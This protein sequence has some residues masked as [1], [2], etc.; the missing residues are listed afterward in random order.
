MRRSMKSLKK[1]FCS[2]F[3]FASMAGMM[4]A[5]E[6]VQEQV[7]AKQINEESSA[8]EAKPEEKT[9]DIK[10]QEM[11]ELLGQLEQLYP[12]KV[13]S[14]LAKML[15]SSKATRKPDYVGSFQHL[16]ARTHAAFLTGKVME[17]PRFQG[18][19]ANKKAPFHYREQLIQLSLT[20]DNLNERLYEFF[21]KEQT[22]RFARVLREKLRELNISVQTILQ[23]T[24]VIDQIQERE[25]RHLFG[26]FMLWC[27]KVEP[28]ISENN[29]NKELLL[30]V[31]KLLCEEIAPLYSRAYRY[32]PPTLGH[33][34]SRAQKTIVN[35][36]S[37]EI[38]IMCMGIALLSV[39]GTK[40]YEAGSSWLNSSSS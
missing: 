11:A 34:C 7:G 24:V 6:P 35:F 2:A 36:L 33:H 40:L 29:E 26:D 18:S 15:L 12:G 38:V 3:A 4:L 28:K 14:E 17:V 8:R 22:S 5:G 27:R 20:L 10:D 21:K 1:Y 39:T 31:R 19:L 30:E 37:D 23:P 25:L 16:I 9:N 13:N 32:P